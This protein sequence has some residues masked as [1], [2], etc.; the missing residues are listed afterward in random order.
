MGKI[1]LFFFHLILL[2]KGWNK[3]IHGNYTRMLRAILNRSWRQHPTK[4]QLYGHQP[5]IAKTI[6]IRRTRHAA[7]CWS[8]KDELRSDVLLWTPSHGRAKAG[9][10]TYSSSVYIRGVALKTCRKRWTIGRG[11]ERGSG[12]SLL[13]A[14]QDDDYDYC[15]YDLFETLKQRANCLYCIRVLNW[16]TNVFSNILNQ[17]IVCKQISAYKIT[18]KLV[19]GF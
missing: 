13:M 4:K 6:Q 18:S 15:Y 12:I 14:R 11:G 1:E 3:K 16:V 19:I 10:P 9:W 8:S 5:P 2:L 17:L 7:Q